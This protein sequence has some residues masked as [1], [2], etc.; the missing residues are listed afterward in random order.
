MKVSS[1]LYCALFLFGTGIFNL[2]KAQA[3]NVDDSLALVD[4]YNSTN[5]PA[6]T[7]HANW[8]TE[9]PVSTWSGVTITDTRITSLDLEFNNLTGPIPS[10]IGNLT[11]L[12]YLELQGNGLSGSIPSSIGKLV[13]LVALELQVNQLNGSIPSSI[14]KLSKLT[15]LNLAFNQ[16]SGSLP[17]SFGNLLNLSYAEL[18][19][20]QISTLPSSIGKLVNL[21]YL[22]LVGNK[23]SG[24]IPSSIG[25]ML[26]L[27][28]LNLSYNHL[29]GSIPSS[30]SKLANLGSLDLSNNQLTGEVPMYLFLKLLNLHTLYLMNNQL[31][32]SNNYKYTQT[33]KHLDLRISIYNNDLNFNLLEFIAYNYSRPNYAPQAS[34]HIHQLSN[35]LSVDAG[36]TLK[37]NTYKWF[38]VGSTWSKTISGDSTFQPQK[39]GKYYA[40]VTNSIAWD[41]TL[42]TD[43]VSYKIPVIQSE[44]LTTMNDNAKVQSN[45]F[46]VYPNPASSIVHIQL[47]GTAVVTITNSAGQVILV[48]T[49][50]NSSD[51]DVSSFTNGIY[52][53]QNGSNGQ[54]QKFVVLH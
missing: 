14:G 16:L 48:K 49:I 6:W 15:G 7:Y 4:L 2:T 44:Q 5:G 36:G 23:L 17:Y 29:S 19:Y 40:Q 12:N 41:L 8:L 22:E 21:N 43:T 53:I 25:K 11:K 30:F 34:I 24:S 32:K 51:I 45:L 35:G 33:P 3:V 9:K 13:N 18:E 38:K 52:Y 46:R 20:N 10:S 42:N 1:I 39:S 54:I 28:Y 27:S 37:N 31:T 26:S 47:S 50:N